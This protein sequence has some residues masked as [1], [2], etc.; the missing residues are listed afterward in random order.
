MRSFIFLLVLMATAIGNIQAGGFIIVMP[1]QHQNPDSRLPHSGVFPLET[2]L[3]K[4][5]T[6]IAEQTATTSIEQVFMNT[7]GRQLEG[8]FLFPVP[9]DVIINKFTMFINGKETEAEMLDATKARQIYEQIVRRV[10]DPALLEYYNQGLFRVRIFPILPN[11]EQ[12]I[13]LTYSETLVKDNGTIEYTFPLNTQKF[14]AKPVGEVSFKVTVEGQSK[15][16]NIYC[17]THEVEIIR[18]GD[19]NATVGFEAKNVVPDRDFQLYYN[20]DNA[21]V[22][23]SLLTQHI[24][25]EDGYFFLNLSPGVG[26][27]EEVVNKD[28]VF[29][30]D[31]S[32][33]MSGEKMEQGKKALKF[34]VENLNKGDR[35]EIVPF[36]TEASS[37]F[38]E[39]KEWSDDTKKQARTFIE[40]LRS[41]GGTNIDE[42]FEMALASQ[43]TQKDRPFFVIFMTDGKPTIGETQEEALLKKIAAHNKNNVRIFTFG[44]GTDLNTHLLDKITENAKG[45][46]T[47]VLP[48][49]DIEVKVSDFYTKASSPVLT[50]V[51]IE[52]DKNVRI[53]DVYPKQI[54]DLFKG[55]TA[56][57]MGRF[58]GEG[59]CKIRLTGKVNGKEQVFEYEVELKKEK[60][61]H[62]FIPDL[63]A[64][65]AVGYLLDQ[66]RL[67]GEN[68]ELVDEVVRLA[69]K[70]GII[71]PYTSYLILEDEARLASNNTNISNDDFVM[72][73]RANNAPVVNTIA[74]EELELQRGHNKEAAKSGMGSVQLSQQNQMMSETNNI[75]QTKSVARDKMEYKDNSGNTLNLSDGITSVQGRSLYLNNNQWVDSQIVEE[76]LKN[77]NL[78]NNRV[79]F[80]SDEYFKLLENRE[81]AEFL[82]LGRNVRFVMDDT[83]YEV[84]E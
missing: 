46:R 64:S 65:R 22:G 10:Q 78:K 66:I 47:Y 14:A 55:A 24:T 31:K 18:K 20:M 51:K 57:I 40:E 45:Y 82:A 77:K 59:K 81:A 71:T 29:V 8:Y 15:I 11:V 2:R 16:K 12:R 50:D 38:G 30:F 60:T 62:K 43:K 34:C 27:S 68:K 80:N 25:G 63:W 39:V 61:D 19:N 49:E 21:K 37:L 28:I 42:A 70:H 74:R 36:S 5:E 67:H 84:F 69:K 56:G 58:N 41:V 26:A 54:P 33:S 79:K 76:E 17:P 1:D 9:K 7:S 35:F 44:I 13:K 83:V 53:S 23:M 72:R 6:A 48:D 75:A 32:G 52:F 4:V 3:T 73:P